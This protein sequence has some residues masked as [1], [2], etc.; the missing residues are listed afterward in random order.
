MRPLK[1]YNMRGL[2]LSISRT[3]EAKRPAIRTM[4]VYGSWKDSIGVTV[5]G[6]AS[7]FER[8]LSRAIHKDDQS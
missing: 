8:R 2:M 7:E 1:I 6:A 5:Y 4:R 3:Q